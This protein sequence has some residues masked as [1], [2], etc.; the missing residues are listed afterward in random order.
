MADETLTA[1]GIKS[2]ESRTDKKIWLSRSKLK[3]GR[4]LNEPYIEERAQALGF[5]IIHPEKIPL[6]EQIRLI[7]TSAAVAGFSGSQFFS[8]FFAKKVL[9]EFKIFNRRKI[10]PDS[11]PFL[12]EKKR[13]NGEIVRYDIEDFGETAPEKDRISLEPDKIV[14]TLKELA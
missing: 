4:V 3:Y 9:G 10:V 13:I 1:L 7:A 8:A 11:L 14:Q 5:D 12:L 6:P 2:F